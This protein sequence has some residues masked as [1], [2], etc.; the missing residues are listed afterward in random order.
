MGSFIKK[1]FLG[2]SA[3]ALSISS[4]AVMP[5]SQLAYA[6]SNPSC[7][8]NGYHGETNTWAGCINDQGKG[9]LWYGNNTGFGQRLN[10]FTV[11]EGSS[12][13]PIPFIDHLSTDYV[14][15]SVE[16][17][18]IA[19]LEDSNGTH[20]SSTLYTMSIRGVKAGNTNLV[21][22][23][24]STG[25][26]LDTVPIEVH[27]LSF[28]ENLSVPIGS[29]R[30][31]QISSGATIA[32]VEAIVP[33]DLLEYVELNNNG[34]GSYTV[35]VKS[36]PYLCLG[37]G[38]TDADKQPVNYVNLRINSKNK[39]TGEKNASET[40]TIWIYDQVVND[41]A[42]E[43]TSS[44]SAEQANEAKL[45]GASNALIEAVMPGILNIV[46]GGIVSLTDGSKFQASDINGL[47]EALNAGK[48]LEIALTKPEAI[49]VDQA[50]S[51]KMENLLP[52]GA[53]GAR[54]FDISVLVSAGGRTFGKL[55]EVNSALRVNVDVSNDQPVPS[56]YTRKYY[57]VRLHDGI[58]ERINAT[59][60]ANS[61]T[62]SFDSPLFS[63]YLIA[64]EDEESI[65]APDSGYNSQVVEGSTASYATLVTISAVSIALY[66]T[67]K[68]KKN[69]AVKK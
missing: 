16:D 58:A 42:S 18:T 45:R 43:A 57:V 59:F 40:M 51:N 22:K 21:Y 6:D 31:F 39:N 47:R 30:T 28:P 49:N 60:Y 2:A 5:F 67:Y 65:S 62:I 13:M 15:F 4:L 23:L 35:N 56:G 1:A 33:S 8:Y 55:T 27:S 68:F 7:Y 12:T 24:K 20:Q 44:E 25:E 14:S 29:A 17:P 3:F 37:K 63:T 54:Y 50:T 66:I 11:R 64:Y 26:V 52:S 34:S 53:K 10:K 38:C 61:K 32:D 36:R 9:G 69:H 41:E 46:N 19:L 48:A